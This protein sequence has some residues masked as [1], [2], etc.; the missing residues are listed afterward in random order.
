VPGQ[1]GGLIEVLYADDAEQ[2][3]FAILRRL[4]RDPSRLG[5]R[6]G[7]PTSGS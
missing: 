3:V 6:P 1:D 5:P 7:F 2:A 4:R